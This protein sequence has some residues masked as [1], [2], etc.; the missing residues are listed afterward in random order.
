MCEIQ[1]KVS[2]D[3]IRRSGIGEYLASSLSLHPVYRT[4][5]AFWLPDQSADN[6]EIA[7][8]LLRKKSG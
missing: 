4:P 2:Y 7:K 3:C 1:P 8:E 5:Q 6:E